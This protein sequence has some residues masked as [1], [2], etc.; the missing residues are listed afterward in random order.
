MSHLFTQQIFYTADFLHS[1][2]TPKYAAA[3]HLC[4]YIAALRLF[5]QQHY[6]RTRSSITH[7]CVAVLIMQQLI[8]LMYTTVLLTQHHTYAHSITLISAA[9]LYT[10]RSSV[11]HIYAT[12]AL[13]ASTPQRSTHQRHCL[14]H[15]YRATALHASTP[16]RSAH[17]HSNSIAHTNAAT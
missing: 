10:Q 16:Q 4:S 12:I 8:T 1:N 14:A 9:A 11:A 13:H 7:I 6:T 5:M 2:I 15:I 17:I 3:L